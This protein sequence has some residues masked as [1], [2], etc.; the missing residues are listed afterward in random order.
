MPQGLCI[1]GHSKYV[2]P[3]CLSLCT[4]CSL[5]W[6]GPSCHPTWQNITDPLNLDNCLQLSVSLSLCSMGTCLPLSWTH[7][8]EIVFWHKDLHITRQAQAGV[9][10]FLISGSPA[11]LH[12]IWHTG[13]IRM[14][15][16]GWQTM[17]AASYCTLGFTR[18]QPQACMHYMASVAAFTL[19]GRV[20]SLC[21]RWQLTTPKIFAG[22]LQKIVANFPS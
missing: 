18:S 2:M 7:H 8:I 11:A 1:P 17:P 3:P 13:H 6:N 12:C 15:N 9:A 10:A 4:F 14:Q 5:T 20:E 22:L 19:H 16:K 21:Q